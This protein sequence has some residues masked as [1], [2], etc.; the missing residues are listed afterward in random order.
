MA[1]LHIVLGVMVFLIALSTQVAAEIPLF[2]PRCENGNLIAELNYT[3]N[4]TTWYHNYTVANTCSVMPLELFV[5]FEVVAFVVFIIGVFRKEDIIFTLIAMVLFFALAVQA[6]SIDLMPSE[7]TMT[8]NMGMGVI[9]FIYAMYLIFYLF[10]RTAL[11]KRE[12]G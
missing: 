8:I 9:C 4:S 7:T 5:L 2:T 12:E 11:E 3:I 10:K 6:G 1:K